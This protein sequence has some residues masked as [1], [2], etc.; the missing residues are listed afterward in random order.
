MFVGDKGKILA[1]FR[2]ENPRLIP[3][4]R[5]G[6]PA[7]AT[8]TRA[9]REPG[10]LSPGLRQWVAACKG[11]A[12]S[13]GSFLH[14]GGISEAVNLYAVAL[15]TRAPSVLRRR[16]PQDHQRRRTPTNI[17]PASIARAG[18]PTRYEL[19]TKAIPGSRCRRHSPPAHGSA[20]RPAGHADRLPDLAGARRRW[21]KI[22]RARC[23]NSPP[24]ASRPSRCVRRTATRISARW[25]ASPPR[26]YAA[27]S[28]VR[29]CA[30]RAVTTASANL[31]RTSTSAWPS[32][33]NS[34]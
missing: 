13:P 29:D 30:A 26:R 11:G 17:F 25:P 31:R 21:P 12:Q 7:A 28:R 1:G 10:Q 9:P 15:R 22:S 8:A 14:A 3:D 18:V 32:P 4:R 24:S 2:V 23:A 33:R 34:A 5:M 20:R 6:G 27:P 16:Q 19:H